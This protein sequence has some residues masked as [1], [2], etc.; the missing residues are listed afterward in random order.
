MQIASKWFLGLALG[1]AA[2]VATPASVPAATGESPARDEM[3]TLIRSRLTE[4]GFTTAQKIEAGRIVRRHAPTVLPLV[5][6]WLQERRSLRDLMQAERLDEAALRAQSTRLGQVQTELHLQAAR[7]FQ[8][9]RRVATPEQQA[10]LRQLERE[11]R[12]KVDSRL[13]RL[14]AWLTS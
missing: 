2:L 3:R 7:A 10:K 13:E 1:A 11:V 12:A 9:L 5:R 14:G 6:Q 8:D 4:A